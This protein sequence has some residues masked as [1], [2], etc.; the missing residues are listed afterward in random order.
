METASF[1]HEIP[2][3]VTLAQ[4]SKS[5][6]L[7][8]KPSSS[9][10]SNSAKKKNLKEKEEE[11]CIV[12]KRNPEIKFVVSGHSRNSLNTPTPSKAAIH[13][14]PLS[15]EA[16]SSAVIRGQ[17]VRSNLETEFPSFVKSLVRSHVASCFWMGLPGPFCK[18]HL[19]DEDTTITLE[20]EDGKRYHV[21]YIAYK[22]GL[23]AGWRQF[24]VAHKLLEGDVLVFQLVEPT[25]FKVYVIRANDLTE[26]DGA[27]GLL[28]LDC[29]S[30]QSDA[31]KDYAEL[32]AIECH[33]TNRKRQKSLPLTVV[34]KK[35][36][37][38][39]V[40]PR[41]APRKPA[42][43]S[44]NDSEEVAS[45]VLEES[46]ILGPAFQFKDMKSFKN[47]NIL[48]D[49]M[50]VDS[51]IPEDI[52]RAYYKL[53]SSQKAFLHDNIIKGM[54]HKL[55]VGTIIET[56][57]VA[58]AIKACKLTTSRGDFEA[59]DK[60]LRAFELLGMNVGILRSRL[61]R[62]T[63]LSRDS[64]VCVDAKMYAE[65]RKERAEV[66]TGMKDIETK[67]VELRVAC[68]RFD[69]AIEKLGSQAESYEHKFHKEVKAPW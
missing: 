68:V 67:I 27:L 64:E 48:V 49:G 58:S 47:F 52:R 43:Q 46:K 9:S 5:P 36:K 61:S 51:E 69:A 65:S 17:E 38:K 53:C 2:E 32:G 55:I 59:W 44:E 8:L 62:L 37:K 54:N 22:T 26:V 23:S 40:S 14:S 18:S 31:D 29:Q 57:K 39:T 4:L 56:V 15:G 45:E 34:E 50:L 20:D 63:G 19:P 28:N 33:N 16:K 21:K 7:K 35:K 13:A 3:D 10:S 6:R 1:E 30:K 41:S 12:K 66:E 42:D 11:L 24:S 60:S 25:K